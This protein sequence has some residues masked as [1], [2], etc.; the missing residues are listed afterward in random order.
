M[1]E[2]ER[3]GWGERKKKREERGREYMVV[4]RREAG[5]YIDAADALRAA[6]GTAVKAA[7]VNAIPEAVRAI[8]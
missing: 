5:V 3:R 2:R 7:R 1:G 8:P 6:R 4:R